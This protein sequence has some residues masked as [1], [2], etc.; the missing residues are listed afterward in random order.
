MFIDR[1]LTENLYRQCRFFP[2]VVLTGARQTGKSALLMS[3]FPNASLIS[4]D[5]P[6]TA[7]QANQTPAYLLDT[8]HEP[9]IIDEIQYAPG[10]FRHLKARIDADR[11][12]MGRFLL[13][14]SQRFGLMEHVSESLAGRTAVMELDTLSSRELRA[15]P[16]LADL[17]AANYLWRGG[18]PELYREPEL[19]SHDFFRNYLVT[20]LERD[21]RQMLNV[22][23]LRDF[24]RFIR[25]CA[26]RNA[27][28]RNLS[29]L[30]RDVGIAVS[31]ARDWISKLEASHLITLLEP[32]FGNIGKRLSKTPK[33]YFRDTG[34]LCFLLGFDSPA[35]L[36]R[37][38][39]LGG[40]W[41]TFLLGEMLRTLQ[42]G[43]TAA[44]VYYFRDAHGV[45]VDFVIEQDGLVRLAEAK[46]AEY[47]D[48]SAAK[49]I[50][51]VHKLLGER[52]AEEH[53]ILCNTRHNVRLDSPVPVRLIDGFRFTGWFEQTRTAA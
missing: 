21:L 51:K 6:S 27:Q 8:C 20:Y 23:S 37:S 45:E 19:K 28:L 47:P 13:T 41:E 5:L 50:A 32:W 48:A 2:A 38:S 4:L 3:A 22:G 1:H 49:G 30:A 18:Y 24:E 29:D 16:E 34:L 9:I 40:M 36:L 12:R 31:T 44:R 39:Y 35:A 33:L 15:H 26:A 14:G 10:L 43:R 46:W 11:H 53:W 7:E 17:K 42:A 52:A 25:A